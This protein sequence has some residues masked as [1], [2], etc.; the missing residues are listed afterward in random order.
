MCHLRQKPICQLKF[1]FDRTRHNTH[2][3]TFVPNKGTYVPI[4]GTQ[5]ND[6]TLASALFGKVRLA[7][8]ALLFGHPDRAFYVRE[9]VRAVEGG[10]GAVQRELARLSGVGLLLRRED[11]RQVYYQANSENPL[12]TE[13]RSIMT[14]TVGLAD[15]LRAALE[16]VRDHISAAFVYGSVARGDPESASDVDLLVVGD[17]RFGEVT[18]LLSQTQDRIGREVNPSVFP[19]EEFR[20]RASQEGDFL[21]R[22]WSGR[23]V[24]VIGDEREFGQL[25]G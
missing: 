24:F 18:E 17:V 4:M 1:G 2:N 5:S 6:S 12:Y 22:V 3:L 8:L 20:R 10:Q 9:V 15:V 7:V 19:A 25:A 14:K 21:A 11:G 16:P 23:K 13:L